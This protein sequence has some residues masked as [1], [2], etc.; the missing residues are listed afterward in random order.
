MVLS[1]R[2]RLRDLLHEARDRFRRACSLF[3]RRSGANRKFE[4]TDESRRIG[5]V[6]R[7]G[8]IE[9]RKILASERDRAGPPHG[10]HRTLEELP[11][12]LTCDR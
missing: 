12:H 4:E 1:G 5:V 10:D 3:N 6:V 9:A 8:M 11:R 7:D 2:P